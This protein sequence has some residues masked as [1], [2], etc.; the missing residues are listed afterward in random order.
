VGFLQ[1]E[2]GFFAFA[3]LLVLCLAQPSAG[4]VATTLAPITCAYDRNSANLSC[5]S[6]KWELSVSSGNAVGFAASASTNSGGSWLSVSPTLGAIPVTPAEVDLAIAVTAGNLTAGTY[7]G[8]VTVNCAASFCPM[9]GQVTLTVTIEPTISISPSSLSFVQ[10]GSSPAGV[11]T[12]S[13]TSDPAGQTFAVKTSAT[14]LSVSSAGNPT[15][16]TLSVT[17]NPT[18]L[19]VGSY[20]GNIT[21]TSPQAINSP[22]TIPVTL[23]VLIPPSI[24]F[25]YEPGLSPPSPV[26][27]LLT[28]TGASASF[29][30]S[31]SGGSWLVVTPNAGATPANVCVSVQ[32]SALGVGRYSGV[33]TITGA[34]A[35][36]ITIPVS[37]TVV[38][39]PILSVSPSSL[40]FLFAIGGSPPSAQSFSVSSSAVLVLSASASTD[41][42]GDWLAVS[43]PVSNTP[44]TFTVSVAPGMLAPGTY[45][46]S[47]VITSVTAANSPLKIP[48]SLNVSAISLFA[49]P[50]SLAFTFQVG[51]N[52]PDPLRLFLFGKTGHG[53]PVA[54]GFNAVVS[55]DSNGG[56][57]STSSNSGNTP[58]IIGVSVSPS[59]LSAGQY[60]GAVTL[61]SAAASNGPQTV[62]VLL[63]V[64]NTNQLSVS[65]S[66]L[67]FD[68]QIGSAQP[69]A[70]AIQLS[71]CGGPMA[72]TISAGASNWLSIDQLSGTTPGSTNISVNPS[73]LTPGVYKNVITVASPV[74]APQGLTVTLVVR[75]RPTLLVRP[76]ALSF[77]YEIGFSTPLAQTLLIS[78]G[79]TNF[80]ASVS[81]SPA[82]WLSIGSVFGTTPSSISVSVQ[83]FG[84]SPGTY[85]GSISIKSTSASNGSATIPVVLTVTR[86]G[87]LF[88]SPA[89][90]SFDSQVGSV[91]QQTQIISVA[92]TGTQIRFTA[93]TG[94]AWLSINPTR[95]STGTVNGSNGVITN[96]PV[97]ATVSFDPTG[98]AAGT[99]S[100]SLVITPDSGS[101]VTVPV[102]LVVRGND[103]TIPQVADGGNWETT[104]VLANTDEEPAPFT[105]SFRRFDGT[106]LTMP[107]DYI[108]PVTNY[109]DV[110]PVG[111]SSTIHTAGSANELSQGW[112]EVVAAKSAGGMT[113]FRQLG[114]NLDTEVAVPI[115]SKTG[116]HFLLPFDNTEG[117]VTA[118]AILNPDHTQPAAVSISFRDENG[119]QIST[120]S[121]VVSPNDRQAFVLAS[122]FPQVVNQ[123]G[124]AEFSSPNIQLSAFGLRA[125]PRHAF[126]SLEPVVIDNLSPPGNPATIS[127][128]A[129]GGGWQTTIILVNTGNKLPGGLTELVPAP[130]SLRFT[131]ANG[132]PWFLPVAG[133]G[134]MSEYSD[135]IPAGGV[136][137]IETEGASPA[138]S[139]GW[140]QVITPGTISGTAIFRQRLSADHDSEGAVP[141]SL[142]GTR[143]FVL[144]FDN[145][146]GVVTAVALANQDRSHSTAVSVTLRNENGQVVGNEVVNLAPLGRSAFVLPTQFHETVNIRGV[147]EFSSG[148]VD[149]SA[150]GL[151]Y[152]PLGSFTSIPPINK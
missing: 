16:T 51:C 113:I 1:P 93:S 33:V 97:L 34:A 79:T 138:V 56:W 105:L 19:T 47:V 112:A 77:N 119:K 36:P 69:L 95:A 50:P 14:W 59:G 130:F 124:V 3:A 122:E 87:S 120:E 103:L 6:S 149:L 118:I 12:L 117:F 86:S 37:L 72:F 132:T 131:Q 61:T 147:A 48:V 27:F 9:A 15:P 135:V 71:S 78:A 152:N 31:V 58:G 115:R 90:L 2:K 64:S 44:G 4:Q 25:S 109:A 41:S 81:S 83:P 102:T 128:V 35:N 107:L 137:I 114:V 68:Y 70:K 94:A 38:Q 144:P 151:R 76:N 148:N 100:T 106:P 23:M 73:N 46:G 146:Q 141:L 101:P 125:S 11:Q 57:L 49:V 66:S 60:H 136:R 85:N 10:V 98:L 7:V 143:R 84:L 123:R 92:S 52:I 29:N 65:P 67:T 104:M 54:V 91:M 13:V 89:S 63:T 42:G 28:S 62:P 116:N 43:P 134:A 24:A 110:I 126:T 74:G 127:Q 8:T 96:T 18:G 26:C 108:G 40:S 45:T 5:S 145:T 20:S 133:A 80:T 21:V 55:A 32:P 39:S 22:V 111:G 140:A 75:D 121:L 30:A 150:L 139:Q 82:G 88:A 142:S 53:N 99:Y 17:I 129:D